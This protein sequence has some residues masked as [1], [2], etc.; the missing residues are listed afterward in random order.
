[1]RYTLI[2][3]GGFEV[4]MLGMMLSYGKTRFEDFLDY[5]T[6]RP[7]LSEMLFRRNTHPK[8]HPSRVLAVDG[9]H[10]R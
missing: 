2:K 4:A 9:L 1:M 8:T 7:D 3:Y 5:P 10:G 6:V